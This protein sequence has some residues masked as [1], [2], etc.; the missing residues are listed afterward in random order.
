MEQGKKTVHTWHIT[1]A[2][3]GKK[4]NIL[5]LNFEPA[6]LRSSYLSLF[7]FS[8]PTPLLSG[9]EKLLSRPGARVCLQILLHG[10]FWP[11]Q[12]FPTEKHNKC[13]KV[14][15]IM[16]KYIK[17]FSIILCTFPQFSIYV[18]QNLQQYTVWCCRQL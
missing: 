4:G 11:T 13:P 10:L 3:G 7:F 14:K 12:E 9:N 15:I 1:K 18:F 8:L 16:L 2:S 17:Y 6:V 5:Q